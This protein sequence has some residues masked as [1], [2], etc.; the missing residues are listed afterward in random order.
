MK[1]QFI[2]ISIVVF[3]ALTSMAQSSLQRVN[4]N[5]KWGYGYPSLTKKDKLGYPM[6]D[7]L[8]IPAI[9]EET[10][11]ETISPVGGDIAGVKLNG[12]WG[13][14]DAKGDTKIPFKYDEASFFS[15]GLAAV[16]QSGKYGFIDKKGVA[17][18]PLKYEKADIFQDG[19]LAYVELGGKGG[20]I[21]KTGTAVIPLKY[22]KWSYLFPRKC[23][24]CGIMNSFINGKATVVLDGK[25]G[26]IDL[27]GNFTA[28]KSEGTE[29]VVFSGKTNTKKDKY[30]TPLGVAIKGT[31][32]CNMA[33]DIKQ[34]MLNSNDITGR[35]DYKNN[36]LYINL[37]NSYPIPGQEITVT[38]EHLSGCGCTYKLYGDDQGIDLGAGQEKSVTKETA[39]AQVGLD[40]TTFSGTMV[41]AM[42]IIQ[43]NIGASD[44]KRVVLNDL[45]ITAKLPSGQRKVINLATYKIKMGQKVTLKVVHTKASKVEMLEPKGI[46]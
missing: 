44:I 43:S 12:K 7:N 32:D 4:V 41:G 35:S 28:C 42:A 23:H 29:S 18:I 37:A 13:Y 36:I 19:G 14:I 25:C 30:G 16:S 39:P 21:N 24:D 34:I 10:N 5:G 11:A 9:Y 45:D 17:V 20:F 27:K 46:K 15:E 38:I 31:G 8:T 3:T 33:K 6:V 22:D 1:K 40:S 2:I 26:N